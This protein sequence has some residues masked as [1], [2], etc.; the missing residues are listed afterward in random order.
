M[1]ADEAVKQKENSK[2]K[3]F[4]VFYVYFEIYFS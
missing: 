1:T 3:I 4:L 2:Q